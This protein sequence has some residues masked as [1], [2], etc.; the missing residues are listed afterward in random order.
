MRTSQNMP[1]PLKSYPRVRVRPT[2]PKARRSNPAPPLYPRQRVQPASALRHRDQRPW[3]EGRPST[4][5]D[6]ATRRHADSA[7]VSAPSATEE[8]GQQRGACG[9]SMPRPRR[10]HASTTSLAL[11]VC[12]ARWC[13]PTRTAWYRSLPHSLGRGAANSSMC[14]RPVKPWLSQWPRCRAKRGGRTVAGC[15]EGCS[16]T[17]SNAGDHLV[18]TASSPASK[19]SH[20]RSRSVPRRTRP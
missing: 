11:A 3:P 13:A 9:L 1:V 8:S 5:F 19:H 6:R 4:P 17:H 16:A 10:S 15:P 18:P 2:T 14:R 20:L 7:I 12:T